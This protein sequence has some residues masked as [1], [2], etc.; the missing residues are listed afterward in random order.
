[1]KIFE[2]KSMTIFISKIK[3]T[4][5]LVCKENNVSPYYQLFYADKLQILDHFG[6]YGVF[7]RQ[8]ND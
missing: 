7:T 8:P 3:R 5:D 4:V 2:L 6:I 1:M